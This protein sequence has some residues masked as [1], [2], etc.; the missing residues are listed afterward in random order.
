VQADEQEEADNAR[1]N[2]ARNSGGRLFASL[3][4]ANAAC[5]RAVDQFWNEDVTV[6]SLGTGLPP[7]VAGWKRQFFAAAAAASLT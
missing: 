7:M 6:I 4:G 5:N 2:G 3:D 1:R